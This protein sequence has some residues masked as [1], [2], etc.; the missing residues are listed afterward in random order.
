MRHLKKFNESEQK[1]SI[2]NP[3][4]VK[5]VPNKLKVIT[6]NGEFELTR[7]NEITD[8]E[9]HPV[10]VSNLLNCLQITYFQNTLEN[11]EGDATFDGEPDTMEF[12]ITLVKDNDGSQANPDSLRL[13]VD[14]TYGDHI[15]YSFT[16]DK[17]NKVSV[18]HYTGK[19]SLYDKDTYW[20]FKYDSLQELVNFFNR[21][22]YSTTIEDFKFMDED[23]DSY[24]Y[25][26][27]NQKHIDDMKTTGNKL[28]P[29]IMDDEMKNKV[30][31]LKG[32][33]KIKRYNEFT[34][35]KKIQ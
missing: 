33:D 3:E 21:F 4:W 13:N 24:D 26:H 11:E 35:S 2:F 17:P 12:D 25:Q 31:S 14:L 16:I 29:M 19:D 18:H 32:G 9:N 28:E 8:G 22:G 20:G 1:I 10:D 15:Q 7:N 30:D 34:A 23:P 6:N 5:L 27:P